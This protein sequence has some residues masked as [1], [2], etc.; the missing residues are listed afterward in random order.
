MLA[1]GESSTESVGDLVDW[2]TKAVDIVEEQIRTTN[3]L[4][5]A[6]ALVFFIVDDC[7]TFAAALSSF[8]FKQEIHFIRATSTQFDFRILYESRTVADGQYS[9]IGL[10]KDGTLIHPYFGVYSFGLP[11]LAPGNVSAD[12][13]LEQALD[14]LHE[15][16]VPPRKWNFYV[17][18]GWLLCIG[19]L[20]RF[21]PN[22]K[23]FTE[24]SFPR[25]AVITIII[26]AIGTMFV[27]SFF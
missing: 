20:A 14:K 26:A 13:L 3:R 16:P 15:D 25:R 22:L 9:A 10:V 1:I 19:V 17:F 23:S 5:E 7:A 24:A 8:C 27:G 21:F 4:A 11:L 12:I 6:Q 18:V 2:G